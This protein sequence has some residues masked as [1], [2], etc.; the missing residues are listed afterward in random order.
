MLKSHYAPLKP[1][2][3]AGLDGLVDRYGAI[4]RRAFL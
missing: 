3:T 1:V 4:R 2:F